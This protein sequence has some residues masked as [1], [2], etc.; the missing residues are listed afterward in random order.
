MQILRPFA[1]S[2]AIG[3]GHTTSIAGLSAAA[4]LLL[5][6]LCPAILVRASVDDF[7]RGEITA[8]VVCA[9]DA[10]QS[11]A[12]FLPSSYTPSRKWP[13]VYAFDPGARGD[14]PL[15]RF[16]NAAEK[17]GYI[18]VGSYNS[19]NGPG[20]PLSHIV[21]TLW[22]DTHA[23][24]PIDEKRTY[25]AGF[26]G[27]ARVA[28]SVAYAFKSQ[29]T[30]VIA[31]GA[32]F[33][34][35]A[36][37]SR[38]V[39]LVVFS[40]VG[41]YDFNYPELKSVARTLDSLGVPNRLEEFDGDHDWAPADVCVDALE[42]MEIEAMRAGKRPKDEAMIDA[43]FARK[44]EKARA[45]EAANAAYDFYCAA[46][47]LAA[48]FKGLRD[49]GEF[50]K[51]ANELKDSKE[52]REALKQEK[53][54]IEK[55]ALLVKELNSI[56]ARY[57]DAEDRGPATVDMKRVVAELKKKSDAKDSPDEQ[58]PARR[59]FQSFFV[60]MYESAVELLYERHYDDALANLQIADLMRPNQP[61]VL[62][63]LACAYSAAG[64]KKNALEK[65]RKAVE[66]GSVRLSTIENAKSLDSLRADPE[67]KK[68]IEGMKK[69]G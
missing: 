13:I 10:T 41:A 42:W 33:P 25:V 43:A 56:R 49:V 68:V 37:P 50:E 30:G 65:L 63:Q 8:K 59:A 57:R 38:S 62:F 29:I 69:T 26:S 23:R 48:D 15:Q 60:Q 16:K 40:T 6:S 52:V 39:D 34:G 12:L 4:A 2:A 44:R 54:Q 46:D 14:A 35:S 18:V 3:A 21:Q 27:G 51:R 66:T 17:F 53:R 28:Y 24:F 19:K 67:Y 1:L 58:K 55:Q 7:A 45:F 5:V 36:P 11:Y 64:D 9:V 31:C 22:A 47:A 32:G 20:I 61:G